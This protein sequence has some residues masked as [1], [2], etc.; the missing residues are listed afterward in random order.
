[1]L[2][3]YQSH[4][5]FIPTETASQTEIQNIQQLCRHTSGASETSKKILKL[6]GGLSTEEKFLTLWTEDVG[7]ARKKNFILFFNPKVPP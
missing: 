3:T 2:A 6:I 4:L 7:Y 1:M 5:D